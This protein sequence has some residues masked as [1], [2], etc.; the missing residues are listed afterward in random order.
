M[1]VGPTPLVVQVFLLEIQTDGMG[2]SFSLF[3]LSTQTFSFEHLVRM[4]SSPLIGGISDMPHQEEA[5]GQTWDS[6]YLAVVVGTPQQ[7]LN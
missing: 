1:P 7:P 5:S 6:L 4:T 3:L 2:V